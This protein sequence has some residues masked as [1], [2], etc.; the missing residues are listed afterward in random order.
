MRALCTAALVAGLV[1]ACAQAAAAQQRGGDDPTPPPPPRAAEKLVYADFEKVD[2]GRALSSRGGPITVT[3]YQ[4]SDL[5]QTKTKGAPDA[6]DSPELVR[7][8]PDDPNHLG[9]IEFAFAAPNQWAGASIE[10]KGQADAAGKPQADDVT[11]FKKITFQLYA[12]GVNTIRVEA[13]SKGHGTDLQQGY[14]QKVFT[15]RPGLNTYEVPLKTLL[16][17]GWV[18]VKVDPKKI[19]QNLTQLNITAFCEQC[20]PSDGM[21]IVDNVTFEK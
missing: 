18:E 10:I 12:K 1:T 6:P 15:V 9:K 20:L 7:I 11:A 17:P 4:E 3:K 13:I 14:P 5:H 8:K 19:L 16:Q 21:L 2:N